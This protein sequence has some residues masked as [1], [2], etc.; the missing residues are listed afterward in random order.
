MHV[1][2]D[3]I[4]QKGRGCM[5][6]DI[7]NDYREKDDKILLAQVLDKIEMCDNKNKI[8]YTDFLDLAQIEL[9]QKFI[10]KLKIIFFMV[11]L[12]RLKE[13]Y[14]LSIQKNLMQQ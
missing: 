7:L 14:L 6:R 2:V 12:N 1:V 3:R 5:N 4:I 10:N 9:V 11:A 8:E 13:R